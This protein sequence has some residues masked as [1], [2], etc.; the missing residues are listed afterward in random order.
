MKIR[1]GRGRGLARGR[2]LSAAHDPALR[3]KIGER[4]RRHMELQYSDKIVGASY[5]RRIEAILDGPGRT[6]R[7]IN[8]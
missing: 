8:R 7:N 2:V 4:G 5:R 1:S 3:R 6:F